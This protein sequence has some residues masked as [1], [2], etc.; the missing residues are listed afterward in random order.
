MISLPTRFAGFDLSL[1]HGAGVLIDEDGDLVDFV[2][3]TSIKGIAD[4][5]KKRGYCLPPEIAKVKDTKQR[6]MAR[7]AWFETW[8]LSIVKAWSADFIGIE[9]YAMAA[10][11]QAYHIGEVGGVARLIS[12]KYAALRLHDPLSVKM[13]AAH[14]GT[15]DKEQMEEAARTRWGVDFDRVVLKNKK[16][17]KE[18]REAAIDLADALAIAKLLLAEYNLRSGKIAMVDLEHDKERQVFNR[19]TKAYPINLLGREWLKVAA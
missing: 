5:S 19:V 15:A 8:Y 16:S 2:Y 11:N 6:Q 12:C 1:N 18:N 7:L 10:S 4:M 3:Y 13:F 9:D 14:D 17:G